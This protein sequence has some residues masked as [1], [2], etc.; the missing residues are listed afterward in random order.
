MIFDFFFFFEIMLLSVALT[1]PGSC[2]VDQAD[3]ELIEI[4]LLLP[5]KS[6]HLH[7]HN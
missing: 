5:P 4:R 6:M 2:S 7:S 1:V 3:L